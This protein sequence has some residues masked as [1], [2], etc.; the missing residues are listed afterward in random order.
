MLELSKLMQLNIDQLTGN[1]SIAIITASDSSRLR[2]KNNGL[3]CRHESA[4]TARRRRSGSRWITSKYAP[5]RR[6]IL[7]FSVV[8]QNARMRLKNRIAS[9]ITSIA[10]RGAQ[11][12]GGF[13]SGGPRKATERGRWRKSWRGISQ[14]CTLFGITG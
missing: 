12:L 7:Q 8:F 5:D 4:E 13:A 1:H 14:P 6:Q 3:R 11:R 10:P 2:R 9:Q